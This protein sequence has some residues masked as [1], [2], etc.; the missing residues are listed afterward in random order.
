[1]TKHPPDLPEPTGGSPEPHAAAPQD[2]GRLAASLRGF[3]PLGILVALVILLAGSLGGIP[4]LVW[5]GLSRTPL[6]DLGFVRPRSWAATVAIGVLSGAALKLLLKAIVMPLLGGAPINQAYH[7]LL[8]NR[9]ALPSM[10]FTIF[11]NAGFGEETVFRGFLFERLGRLFGRGPRGKTAVIVLSAGLFGLAHYVNQGRDGV[12]Q[13]AITGLVLGTTYAI[14]QEIWLP[15][16]MHASFDLT[17][18]W[19]IYNGLEA[20][21][22]HL[23]FR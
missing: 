3:G 20:R 9:A 14:T 15:M 6:R 13:G 4:A 10:L 18:V 1:M 17:A 8:G 22:A 11:V 5:A 16:I 21:I 2:G 19:I 23:V 12:V 7:Y